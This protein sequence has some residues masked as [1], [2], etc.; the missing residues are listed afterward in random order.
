MPSAML[1]SGL[2]YLL[3]ACIRSCD[4]PACTITPG[5]V[6]PPIP[7][8]PAGGI[9]AL[10]I[11]SLLL[12][13][14]AYTCGCCACT[15]CRCRRKRD[16]V[17]Y[18]GACC[19]L[20]KACGTPRA[21]FFFAVINIA[22]ILSCIAYMGRFADG[23]GKLGSAL[24]SFTT[25]I[26]DSGDL[27][28]SVTQVVRADGSYGSSVY[29]ATVAATNNSQQAINLCTTNGCASAVNTILD[30]VHSGASGAADAAHDI[31]STLA[32]LGELLTSTK[33]QVN[34]D[35]L[36]TQATLAGYAILGILCFIL[37][38]FSIMTCKNRCASCM[39]KVRSVP[40]G[41]PMHA[42]FSASRRRSHRVRHRHPCVLYVSHHLHPFQAH[43]SSPIC[44]A[45]SSSLCMYDHPQILAPVNILLITLLIIL[46]GAFYA[47]GILGSGGYTML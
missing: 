10:A 45:L 6:H 22:L 13:G 41:T 38:S 35:Q 1:R 20:R 7:F 19:G 2:S 21:F 24:D 25:V 26:V 34:I 39:F 47:I 46:T 27:M 32:S 14:I 3:V 18:E 42:I 15:C 8:I 16:R 29:S 17:D 9:I 11:L 28:A 36:K 43:G 40:G 4:A 37:F 33:G 44:R 23:I 12:Y 5:V 30:T 31:G